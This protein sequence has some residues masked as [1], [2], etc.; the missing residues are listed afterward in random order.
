[1]CRAFD[2][3]RCGPF[4]AVVIGSHGVCS[5]CSDTIPVSIATFC[6][7]YMNICVDIPVHQN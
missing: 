3:W 7:L 5:C 1:M 6:N 2:G 4:T